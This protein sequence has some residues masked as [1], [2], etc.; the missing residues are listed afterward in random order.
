[1]LLPKNNM[2]EVLKHPPR[3]EIIQRRLQHPRQK[4]LILRPRPPPNLR[5]RHS[6]LRTARRS[7]HT[8]HV[9]AQKQLRPRT[10]HSSLLRPQRV[11]LRLGPERLNL[12]GTS[13][14]AH[15]AQIRE[16]VLLHEVEVQRGDAGVV[17]VVDAFEDA[18]PLGPVLVLL[19]RVDEDDNLR[20]VLVV[21]YDVGEVGVGFMAFVFACV[22]CCVLVV[23]CVDGGW[24]AW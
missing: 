17:V 19:V 8:R 13:G 16:A 12:R 23:G 1:M 3:R 11:P 22:V 14:Q 5:T 10:R 24:P 4:P 15:A 21:V 2:P 18:R 20:E 9:V 6:K 7:K